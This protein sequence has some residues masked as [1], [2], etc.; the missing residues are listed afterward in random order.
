M[1]A[2]VIGRDSCFIIAEAGVNHNGSFDL[3]L[4]L[5]YAAKKAGADAVKFQTF[6]TDDLVTGKTPGAAY[7]EKNLG[8]ATTQQAM[9]RRLELSHDEFRLLAAHAY[10]LGILFL[11]TP[12]DPASADFLA[13]LDLPLYKIGS[14]ELT[15]HAL[16]RHVARKGRPVILSTGMA[17]LD[18]VRAAVEVVRS[19]KAEVILLHCVSN[20]PADPRDVNL[21]AMQT[22]ADEFCVPV[23][24]S[25]HTPGI[26][27]ALA[28]VARGACVIEKHFTLSRMMEGPDH[29]ASLEPAELKQLVSAIREI[30]SALGSGVK[31]PAASEK[32]VAEAARRSWVAARDLAKDTVLVPNDLLLRRPGTGLPEGQLIRLLGKPLNCALQEGDVLQ[33]IH[34]QETL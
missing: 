20:Y 25:D 24:F 3:A 19:E 22:L 2:P 1:S 29:Q 6:R 26:H 33:L 30:E 8:Y 23:G 31:Q 7:Q 12:F 27:I 13:G 16:L 34:L 32:N 28:A 11:S 17:D 10:A 14:G 21:R 9:L 5:I 15:H 4:Q 18:E